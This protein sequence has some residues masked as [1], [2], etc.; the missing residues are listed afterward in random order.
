VVLLQVLYDIW[1]KLIDLLHVP[2]K[3]T[4]SVTSCSWVQVISEHISMIVLLA[5]GYKWSVNTSH[6]VGI[7]VSHTLPMLYPKENC[8]HSL[9]KTFTGICTY[10][11]TSWIPNSC[12]QLP[13][14]PLPVVFC[15]RIKNSIC[16]MIHQLWP[17]TT[18]VD[19]S[20]PINGLHP[21]KKPSIHGFSATKILLKRFF[22]FFFPSSSISTML[23]GELISIC[24]F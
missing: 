10:N 15:L 8:I 5:V 19:A 9:F 23:P 18:V 4:Q 21:A 22:F 6:E 3:Q 1:S 2:P 17:S 7:Q 20:T 12:M 16:H 24:A 11:Q 14:E 13:H